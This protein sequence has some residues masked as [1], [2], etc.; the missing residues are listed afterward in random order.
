M[1]LKARSQIFLP[2]AHT[3][4]RRQDQWPR[5]R[6]KKTIFLVQSAGLSDKE[7]ELEPQTA[8]LEKKPTSYVRSGVRHGD[9]K[10]QELSDNFLLDT[11]AL[12]SGPG[13]CLAR[14]LLEP[15]LKGLFQR[16][17]MT[18]TWIRNKLPSFQ[19]KQPKKKDMWAELESIRKTSLER[20]SDH[21]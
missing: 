3:S 15:V 5:C 13:K 17:E 8:I 16:S 2:F 4:V 6:K 12:L 20:V 14:R 1:R 19:G 10:V 18:K 11:M 9:L 21:F 7:R